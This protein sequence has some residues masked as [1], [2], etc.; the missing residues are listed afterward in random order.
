MR[1]RS[2]RAGFT[3]SSR[4]TQTNGGIPVPDW[5]DYRQCVPCRERVWRRP[6]NEV[7][8]FGVIRI[9]LWRDIKNTSAGSSLLGSP[10]LYRCTCPNSVLQ[11]LILRLAEL[12]EIDIVT[13]IYALQS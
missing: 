11:A 9:C 8:L 6:L 3:L 7:P 12:T 13:C 4:S 5:S 1:L 2:G 10:T